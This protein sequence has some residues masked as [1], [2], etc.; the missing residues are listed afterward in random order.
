QKR[1]ADAK[2]ELAILG[3]AGVRD[4]VYC[5]LGV[6][7][8]RFEIL[9]LPHVF[10]A[11]YCHVTVPSTGGILMPVGVATSEAESVRRIASVAHRVLKTARHG[12]KRESSDGP[13]VEFDVAPKEF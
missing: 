10:A 6:L 7:N 3:D 11:V 9:L 12:Y 1:R 4:V 2:R 8:P 13:L 5:D